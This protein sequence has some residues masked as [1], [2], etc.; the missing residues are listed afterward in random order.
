L[1]RP[2]DGC[3]RVTPPPRRIIPEAP[4]SPSSSDR[5]TREPLVRRYELD[6]LPV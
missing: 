5:A 6:M 3:T 2:C 4:L 1:H